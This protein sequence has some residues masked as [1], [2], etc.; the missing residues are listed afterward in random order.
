[1]NINKNWII[2]ILVAIIATIF[3]FKCN[4]KLV[5]KPETIRTKV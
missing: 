5:P 1:M 3:L 2:F 4:G